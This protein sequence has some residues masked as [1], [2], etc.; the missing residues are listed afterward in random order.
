MRTKYTRSAWWLKLSNPI[1]GSDE[2]EGDSSEGASG[3]GTQGDSGE[4]QG[5]SG[6]DADRDG[7]G[8]DAAGLKSALQKERNERKA[9][10]KQL[11]GLQKAEQDRTDAEKSEV[12]RLTDKDTRNTEKIQRLGEKFKKNALN[13]AVLNAAR[14]AKFLDPSDALRDDV[15]AEV[16]LEQDPDDPSEITIDEATVTAAV[17]KLAKTKPHWVQNGRPEPKPKSGSGFGGSANGNQQGDPQKDALVSKFP[18]LRGR[19]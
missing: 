14:A 8:D 4:G 17:K 6:T 16:T 10:E 11:R 12:D 1:I 19:V 2:G 13:S 5:S 15:F 3:E 7:A 9:L 18:A